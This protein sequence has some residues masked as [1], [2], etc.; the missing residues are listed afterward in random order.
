MSATNASRVA[1]CE[2]KARQARGLGCFDI[3]LAVADHK[4]CLDGAPAS[5]ASKS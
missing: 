3:G 2:Q 1:A 5:A 4:S